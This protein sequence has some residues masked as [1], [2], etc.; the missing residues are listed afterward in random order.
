MP[1]R[2]FFCLE[3]PRKFNFVVDTKIKVIRIIFDF[4]V[5]DKMDKNIMIIGGVILGL[6]LLVCAILYAYGGSGGSGEDTSK[7]KTDS[8]CRGGKICVSGTCVASSKCKTDS[9]CRD[10]K[11]CVSGACVTPAESGDYSNN[12]NGICV[13]DSDHGTMSYKDC[14]DR[15]QGKRQAAPAPRKPV[16][17]CPGAT[18]A[19]STFE[20]CQEFNPDC[21]FDPSATDANGNPAW[22][23]QPED[24][25][26]CRTFIAENCSGCGTECANPRVCAKKTDCCFDYNALQ[27]VQ[28]VDGSKESIPAWC[29]QSDSPSCRDRYPVRIAPETYYSFQRV[30]EK[31]GVVPPVSSQMDA[32]PGSMLDDGISP[33]YKNRD[34]RFLVDWDCSSGLLCGNSWGKPSNQA[35]LFVNLLALDSLNAFIK[36]VDHRVAYITSQFYTTQVADATHAQPAVKTDWQEQ[37]VLNGP[38]CDDTCAPGYGCLGAGIPDKNTTCGPLNV[39]EAGS[40]LYNAGFMVFDANMFFPS[41]SSLPL[42]KSHLLYGH[43]GS[44]YGY[45]SL[46][47]V[48][49]QASGVLVNN[50]SLPQIDTA[51]VLTENRQNPHQTMHQNILYTLLNTYYTP[52]TL[53]QQLLAAVETV[54]RSS[55]DLYGKP[56][57]GDVMDGYSY[58]LGYCTIAGKQTSATVVVKNSVFVL[59]TDPEPG[60][61]FG[62]GTKPIT[63]MMVINA[64]SEKLPHLSGSDFVK[65]LKG[66]GSGAS[67][68][69]GALP[70]GTALALGSDKYYEVV[71]DEYKTIKEW[72]NTYFS[73][74]ACDYH[75]LTQASCPSNICNTVSNG[76]CSPKC[77][78]PVLQL[79]ST[80]LQKQLSVYD[81]MCMRGGIPDTD[82]NTGNPES[83]IPTRF[84]PAPYESSA[85][86]LE[87]SASKSTPAKPI[88]WQLD[89]V[90][91]WAA[92][93]HAIGP[94]EYVFETVGMDWT[95]GWTGSTPN[96]PNMIN[97]KLPPA[98]YTSSGYTLLGSLLWV[99]A[100]EG[101]GDWLSIDLN[102]M[103]LPSGLQSVA[104]FAGTSGN[105]GSTYIRAKG[106]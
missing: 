47:I 41:E 91:Q 62:S 88:D 38:G 96:T 34:G 81:L 15:F 103:Y 33:I 7:C 85:L 54:Y 72:I 69:Q 39:W 94:L 100:D 98:S 102:K 5:V 99:L 64:L 29:H 28:L 27:T 50:R 86:G 104:N 12:G 10:G 89:T 79:N 92:R 17:N 45:C 80:I 51:F 52:G 59:S 67:A 14:V 66:G 23:Y 25:E 35:K 101:G 49:T 20:A 70:F 9:D 22:C 65:R 31:G 18:G 6:A 48:L 60:Y 61:F 95:P 83:F 44:T 8:D 30:I 13:L 42:N 4:V 73:P 19:Q 2:V 74:S 53:G 24:G 93:T 63:T 75:G 97:P 56:G 37:M 32:V 40:M 106:T 82:T 58:T 76:D 26:K 16:T 55:P 11:S 21:C 78:C 71:R 68:G 57:V 90:E 3:F 1:Y 46:S 84:R 43:Y 36:N 77:N 87:T 105:K